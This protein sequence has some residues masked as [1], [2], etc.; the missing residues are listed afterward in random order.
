MNKPKPMVLV[1]ESVVRK[2]AA[3]DVM[4]FEPESGDGPYWSCCW[5][6]AASY[7][8]GDLLHR[9][10]CPLS[11]ALERAGRK[12]TREE[13]IERR[14]AEI[15]QVSHMPTEVAR[16]ISTADAIALETDADFRGWHKEEEEDA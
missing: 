2:L 9:D 16:D 4:L 14:T 8:N 13:F 11:Q 5:C 15:R 10:D 6:N 12:P 1:P 7:E 3:K